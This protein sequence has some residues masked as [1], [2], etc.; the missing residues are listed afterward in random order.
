[1]PTHMRYEVMMLK[2]YP[3]QAVHPGSNKMYTSTRQW[4][5]WESMVVDVYA[6]VVK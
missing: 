2:Q 6:F 3:P 4:F 1:V 5:H